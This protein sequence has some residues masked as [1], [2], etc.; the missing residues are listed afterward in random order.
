MLAKGQAKSLGVIPPEA[1]FDPLG[2]IRELAKRKIK[3]SH[4]IER[5]H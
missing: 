5:V 3:V 4:R 2:F 1:A